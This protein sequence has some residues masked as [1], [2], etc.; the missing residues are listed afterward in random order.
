VCFPDILPRF[1]LRV[2]KPEQMH[3]RAHSS[4]SLLGIVAIFS[5]S[6]IIRHPDRTVNRCSST[7]W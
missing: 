2:R 6:A 3:G 1:F 7:T 4:N 5:N